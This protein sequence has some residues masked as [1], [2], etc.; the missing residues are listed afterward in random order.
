MRRSLFQGMRSW[1]SANLAAGW[2]TAK[3]DT[4]IEL[5]HPH[6]SYVVFISR[7]LPVPKRAR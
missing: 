2:G 3:V 4:Q 7:G 6:E 1:Y 5:N